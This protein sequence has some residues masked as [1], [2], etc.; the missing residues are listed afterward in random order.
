MSDKRRRIAEKVAALKRKTV[1]AGCSEA[2]A[3]AAAAVAAR[4]MAEHGLRDDD[5]AIAQ[6]STGVPREVPLWQIGLLAA[7]CKATN[8]A[9]VHGR[10]VSGK[11]YVTFY[12]KDPGPAIAC[13]LRD[14]V[15]RAC[16]SEQ[17]RFKAGPSYA[18][19]RSRKKKADAM[20]GFNQ[21]LCLRLSYRLVAL[22]ASGISEA[23][24]KMAEGVME[25][26]APSAA[27]KERKFREPANAATVLEG[28]RRGAEVTL[29]QAVASNASLA[30]EGA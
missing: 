7:I 29:Q 13:Y 4:L 10:P 2:E 16:A 5:I 8:T 17:R 3:M 30:I 11:A 9:A 14:V 25:R 19:L 22:F 24:R 26:A 20:E 27:K 12:G 21:G 28:Y 15:F 6:A 18:A 23:D 1:E